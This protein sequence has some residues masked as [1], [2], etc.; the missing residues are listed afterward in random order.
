MTTVY[1]EAFSLNNPLAEA[2]RIAFA[3]VADVAIGVN[4]G[5]PRDR[6][7]E[8]WIN[9]ED[10]GSGY[11]SPDS[12]VTWWGLDSI[13]KSCLT[14]FYPKARR[15]LVVDTYPNASNSLTEGREALR[16][17]RSPRKPDVAVTYSD[18]MSTVIKQR[19]LLPPGTEFISLLQPFPISAHKD[20]LDD[21]REDSLIFTGRSDLLFERTG[22]M[23]KDALGR[24]LL[25][26]Q[27]LGLH[28]TVASPGVKELE[29]K[30][31]EYGIETYPRLTNEEV[32]RG[33]LASI[34]SK[35][36]FH[37]CGYHVTNPTLARR[38]KLGLSSRFALGLTA[39]TPIV[40]QQSASSAMD[41]LLKQGIGGSLS[42]L[43]DKNRGSIGSEYRSNWR[44]KHQGW[45]IEGQ[46]SKLAEIV[47]LPS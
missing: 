20:S 8:G 41:L 3:S 46:R 28:V 42:L 16:A 17:V 4:V 29:A 35:H 38:I 40:C 26:F 18:E 14:T 44:R 45:A 32:L 15:V 30:L 12:I 2:W 34:I 13:R 43:T 22:R 23:K 27:A 39:S 5:Q 1:V 37:Y 25:A 6:L 7:P 10:L 24:Q 9:K 19:R 36:E 33:D 31:Q 21:P 11:P 47:G